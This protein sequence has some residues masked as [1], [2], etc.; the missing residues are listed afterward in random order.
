MAAVLRK[1]GSKTRIPLAVSSVSMPSF[2]SGIAP[3]RALKAVA[4]MELCVIGMVIVFPVRLSITVRVF[5]SAGL[6][7]RKC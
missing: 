1:A 7:L 4:G 5:L 6:G 3:L 2:V